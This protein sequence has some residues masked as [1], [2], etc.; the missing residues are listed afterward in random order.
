M[1]AY[2]H[3]HIIKESGEEFAGRGTRGQTMCG[4]YLKLVRPAW[5]WHKSMYNSNMK[6]FWVD[7]LMSFCGSW[8]P[9]WKDGIYLGSNFYIFSGAPN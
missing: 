7:S 9:F 4:D 2:T 8:L 6:L 3:I 5:F 1:Y